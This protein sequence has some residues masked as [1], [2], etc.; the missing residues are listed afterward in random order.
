[1]VP[2]EKPARRRARVTVMVTAVADVGPSTGEDE[3][4]VR[5]LL[6]RDLTLISALCEGYRGRL[7]KGAPDGVTALFTTGADAVGCAREVQR[8]LAE[9]AKALPAHE[10]LSH[11]IGLHTGDLSVSGDEV[12]GEVVRA[13]QALAAWAQPNGICMSGSVFETLKRRRA[14]RV[15]ELGARRLG[16]Q[17]PEMQ[18]YEV[19][20]GDGDV[21]GEE[22]KPGQASATQ[23]VFAVLGVAG[24]LLVAGVAVVALRSLRT[25][26]DGEVPLTE[27]VEPSGGQAAANRAAEGTPPPVPE[28]ALGTPYEEGARRPPVLTPPARSEP[29]GLP[30]RARGAPVASAPS[31]PGEES[32]EVRQFRELD[33]NRD[34]VLT[35]QEIPFDLRDRIM[36][37]D[38]NGDG[39][40][41][42]EELKN[43]RQRRGSR[44]SQ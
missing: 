37:A 20:D 14:V 24:L 12:T 30:P 31:A 28:T 21:D 27:A 6:R 43:A 41:T 10:V 15:V 38:A 22:M 19:R 3:D 4:H 5:S 9:Y 18:V 16:A 11:R 33:F 44:R 36:R 25:G 13:A 8:Q 40:V 35:R 23:R 39:A 32:P 1:M 29:S 17:D 26:L 2:Q 42:L 7:V 34:G